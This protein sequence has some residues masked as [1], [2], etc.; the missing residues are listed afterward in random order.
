MELSNEDILL[1]K[2]I[3]VSPLGLNIKVKTQNPGSNPLTNEDNGFISGTIEFEE[4]SDRWL[5]GVPDDDEG[6]FFSLWGQIDKI[7]FL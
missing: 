2:E 4:T 5:T 6:G 3:F 7:R 1:G